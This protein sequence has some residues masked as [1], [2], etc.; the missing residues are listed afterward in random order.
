MCHCCR[1][2]CTTC[3]W[4][5]QQ[6]CCTGT[7]GSCNYVTRARTRSC[8][9]ATS[10]ARTFAVVRN[11]DPYAASCRVCAGEELTYD[12]RFAGQEKLRCNCGAPSCRGW[13]NAPASSDLQAPRPDGSLMLP[14][15]EV[16]FLTGAAAAAAVAAHAA[17][18]PGRKQAQ[19]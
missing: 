1:E 14:R 10:W 12:Y 9:P 5:M 7:A 2:L 11:E 16:E 18:A 4:P 6:T 13:V 17:A 19:P 3:T 15:S 8:L